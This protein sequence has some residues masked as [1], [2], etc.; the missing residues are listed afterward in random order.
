MN[1][2][3]LNKRTPIIDVFKFQNDRDV[4]NC[5]G[6]DDDDDDNDDKGNDDDHVKRILQVEI[7]MKI[8]A[9]LISSAVLEMSKRS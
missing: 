1:V 2:F 7:C 6:D 4:E 8:R 5:G 9:S 3:L